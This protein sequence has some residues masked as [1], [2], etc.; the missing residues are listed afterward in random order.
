MTLSNLTIRPAEKGDAES[1]ASVHVQSWVEAYTGL[2][3]DEMISRFN[4]SERTMNW[5]TLLSDLSESQNGCVYVAQTDG[6]TCGFICAVPQRDDAL[7]AQGFSAEM[8]AVYVLQSA[9]RQGVGRAL[10]RKAAEHLVS[11]GHRGA[12][13]WVLDT[14]APA[15]RFYEALGGSPVGKREDVRPNAT[16]HE[17]AYGWPDLL[18]LSR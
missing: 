1:I 8:A 6:Q 11:S 13:L 17:I 18:L 10:M 5:T 9:Q 2:L 4:V 7:Q 3:P 12:S 16:L 14:N 15:R